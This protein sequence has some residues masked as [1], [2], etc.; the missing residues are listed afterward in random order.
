MKS[1]YILNVHNGRWKIPSY[2]STGREGKFDRQAPMLTLVSSL[3]DTCHFLE[4]V[5][6][7]AA[8][9]LLD[10]PVSTFSESRLYQMHSTS[11]LYD[12][13]I[14]RCQKRG[15]MNMN[16]IIDFMKSHTFP[17]Q[18]STAER[19]GEKWYPQRVHEILL[20]HFSMRATI[21]WF[22]RQLGKQYPSA[23]L[24]RRNVT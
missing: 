11:L 6:E 5:W 2:S 1:G 20:A 10:P 16:M 12:L 14:F 19:R 3:N 17:T 13:N 24:T 9:L 4:K 21:T 7:Q 22:C 18:K 8:P 23:R 15:V